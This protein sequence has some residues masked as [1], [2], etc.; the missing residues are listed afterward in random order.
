MAAVIRLKRKDDGMLTGKVAVVTGTNRGIGRAVVE[1]FAK[2][3]A[4]IFACARKENPEFEKDMKT[5]A[6]EYEVTIFPIYF[7]LSSEEEIKAAVQQIRKREKQIDILVNNAG[8]CPQPQG[9]LMADVQSFRKTMEINFVA[10]MILTQ[11]IARV[12]L[13]RKKGSIVNV[14]SIAALNGSGLG[15]LEYCASKAAIIAATKNLACQLGEYGIRVNAVAPGMTDTEMGAIMRDEDMIKLEERMV[16][17]RKGKPE[18]IADA[19][20]YLASERSSYMTGQTIRIDGGTGL[21][22]L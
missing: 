19:I 10:Q 9:F 4:T 3:K 13:R 18:E 2:E 12:M 22:F 1:T 11:Y 21:K 15:E 5:L 7:D 17:P 14:S 8:I 20:L 16:I 6:E